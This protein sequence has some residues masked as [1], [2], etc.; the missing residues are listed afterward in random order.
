[1]SLSCFLI[2]KVDKVKSHAAFPPS[3]SD[4]VDSVRSTTEELLVADLSTETAGLR[5]DS[6]AGASALLTGTDLFVGTSVNESEP[7]T[8][9]HIVENTNLIGALRIW[10]A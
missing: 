7:L 4:E 8:L 2:V 3:I 5:R 1:M 6:T 10:L 9:L